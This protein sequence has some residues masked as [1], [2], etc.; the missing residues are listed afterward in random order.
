MLLQL[1][2][3]NAQQVPPQTH[4]RIELIAC[5]HSTNQNVDW[6]NCIHYY[7]GTSTSWYEAH[8]TCY[9]QDLALASIP[10]DLGP[11]IYTP[12]W[13]AM[14]RVWERQGR[15]LVH[16]LNESVRETG[17]SRL[18]YVNAHRDWYGTGGPAL[19]NGTKLKDL[20]GFSIQ[21]AHL[22]TT[23]SPC[24]ALV[25]HE[26][27]FLRCSLPQTQ[28]NTYSY[29]ACVF[30]SRARTKPAHE[31]CLPGWKLA[32]VNGV[33]IGKCYKDGG[34]ATTWNN[35]R[36]LCFKEGGDLV[37]LNNEVQRI[38]FDNYTKAIKANPLL[39]IKELQV[40]VNLHAT[41]FCN[42][43]NRWCWANKVPQQIHELYRLEWFLPSHSGRVC[44]RFV[45]W[46]FRY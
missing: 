30:K 38:W 46:R 11:A 15:Q 19:A 17:A 9:A 36:G 28:A 14:H 33:P 34:N 35:A 12:A 7:S 1:A 16:K 39:I 21:Q 32:Q 18:W 42:P 23:D 24:V 10:A 4:S 5:A 22:R 27:Q 31:Q 37:S 8:A 6:S 25:G 45:M 26:F 29:F 44:G 2:I 3:H 43:P 40:F 13:I 20:N 41:L